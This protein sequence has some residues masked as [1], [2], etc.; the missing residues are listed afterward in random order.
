MAATFFTA[1][2]QTG[3]MNRTKTRAHGKMPAVTSATMQR[4][5][6]FGRCPEYKLTIKSDG[7]VIYQ[8]ARNAPSLGTYQKNIGAE[9]AT[10]VLNEFSQYRVDTLQDTYRQTISDVPGLGYTFVINGRE[11]SV[12]NA[13]FGPTFLLSMAELMDNYGKVDANW[14]KIADV[15]AED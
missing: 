12:G 3:K 4:G 1:C 5:A 6:C 8:G 10:K 13:N 2:A 9:E 14:K 11:K 15:K 7:T